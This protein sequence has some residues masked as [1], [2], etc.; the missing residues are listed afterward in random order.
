MTIGDIGS[1]ATAVA[2]LIAAWQV[3]QNNKLHCA[4]YEDAFDRQYRDLA[5]IIPMDIFIGKDFEIHP[6][7]PSGYQV[8]EAIFNYFDLCNEQIYQ[9]QKGRISNDTWRDWSAGIRFNMKLP[10][11]DS[12][13]TELMGNV[14]GTFTYLEQF[15]GGEQ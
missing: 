11:F 15:M 10:A 7:T 4:D 9:R 6:H 1:I 12:V 2:V 3:H 5:M 13:W 8:R 14:G